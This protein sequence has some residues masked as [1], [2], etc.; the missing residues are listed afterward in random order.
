[1]CI[2]Q[3]IYLIYAIKL[4]KILISLNSEYIGRIICPNNGKTFLILL[5]LYQ[6]CVT[7]IKADNSA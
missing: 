7:T 1:M 4:L 6:K 3:K 5:P 2:I